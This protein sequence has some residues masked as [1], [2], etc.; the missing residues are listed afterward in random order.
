[1]KQAREN[2]FFEILIIIII[3]ILEACIVDIIGIGN[4]GLHFVSFFLAI[5]LNIQSK[6]LEE[7][8]IGDKTN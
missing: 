8:E 6:W 5:Y 3:I 7:I 2:C 4:R 1:L